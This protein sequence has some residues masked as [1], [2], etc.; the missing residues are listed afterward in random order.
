MIK[1][2]LVKRIGYRALNILSKNGMKVNMNNFSLRLPVDYFRLFPKDYEKDNFRFINSKV[3]K[4]DII[5]DIGAHI[6]LTAVLFGQKVSDTGRVYSFEPTPVSF[7]VLKETIRINKL[8]NII[9][10][11]NRPVTESTGKVQFFISDTAVDVANSLV[12][13]EDGKKLHG[14][15]LNGTSVDDFVNGEKLKKVNFIKIDA[16]GAEL[17]VLKGAKETLISFKP[18]VILALHPIAIAANGDS[19]HNIYE[20]IQSLGYKIYMDQKE[21]E[22]NSFCE[23]KSLFDVHLSFPGL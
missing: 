21:M 13:Y 18:L 5:L 15:E 9:T 3:K 7:K 8:E 16:E 20:Y 11:V 17:K 12:A 1:S 14:I 10:P 4:G 6:G 23:E 2:K 22:K 19:L